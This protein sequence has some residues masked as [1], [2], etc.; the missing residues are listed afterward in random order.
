MKCP[1]CD[2]VDGHAWVLDDPGGDE[3]GPGKYKRI[4]GEDGG[5]FCLRTTATRDEGGYTPSEERGVYG[6]PHCMKVFM[7]GVSA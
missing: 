3:D 7:L 6:C 1:H 4:C 2:Y 5:F